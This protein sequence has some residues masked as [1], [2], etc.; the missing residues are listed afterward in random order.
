MSAK[1]NQ[2]RQ[3][4]PIC[5]EYDMIRENY[6][7]DKEVDR[8]EWLAELLE[9]HPEIKEFRERMLPV[10]RAIEF[11]RLYLPDN[12]LIPPNDLLALISQ[13]LRTLGLVESQSSL[14]SEWDGQKLT[15]PASFNRS[16]LTFLVQRGIKHAE[17]FWELTMP[18]PGPEDAKDKAKDKRKEELIEEISRVIGGAPVLQD[19]IRDLASEKCEVDSKNPQN[20]M[21]N[22]K[23]ELVSATLNQLIWICTTTNRYNNP[24]EE[25]KLRNILCFMSS[26]FAS[27]NVFF[28][29]LKQRFEI[30]LAETDPKERKNAVTMTFDF[31]C[32]WLRDGGKEISQSLRPDIDQYIKDKKILTQY[33]DLQKV[34]DH[35]FARH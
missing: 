7:S 31:M 32:D 2:E 21:K 11:G 22:E 10:D 12:R 34:T 27:K 5:A 18:E 15:I 28:M 13:H 29:K 26:S 25:Q 33:P 35:P 3:P 14:H 30:A 19:D 1:P 20:L 17:R 23:G 6:F 9:K 16:Q 4:L 8:S 24:P